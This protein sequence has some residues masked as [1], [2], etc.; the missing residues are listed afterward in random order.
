MVKKIATFTFRDDAAGVPRMRKF[1][2]HWLR[3]APLQQSDQ[4]D[5]LLA[6]T[7]AINNACQHAGPRG[8][9]VK[10][11]CSCVDERVSVSVADKGS[12]FTPDPIA[13]EHRPALDQTGGRGL[14]LMRQLA[15]DVTVTSTTR[16]T[17]VT[18]VRHAN[19]ETRA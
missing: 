6:V 2:S 8:H 18:L 19:A 9:A 13:W 16:G 15:D 3:D 12:G 17:T 5:F 10:I 7:E 1:V 14:F 11:S 4:T